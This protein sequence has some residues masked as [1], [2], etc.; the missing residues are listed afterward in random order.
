MSY[1]IALTSVAHNNHSKHFFQSKPPSAS[2][3]WAHRI[4]SASCSS[5]SCNLSSCW[6]FQLPAFPFQ[7]SLRT[8]RTSTKTATVHTNHSTPFRAA[9]LPNCSTLILRS[10]WTLLSKFW[11]RLTCKSQSWLLFPPPLEPKRIS[12]N[13]SFSFVLDKCF[14][15]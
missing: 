13:E 2:K 10:T 12:S 5:S 14:T 6:L 3:S 11:C 7:I 9:Q 8:P 1:K 15:V 4:S